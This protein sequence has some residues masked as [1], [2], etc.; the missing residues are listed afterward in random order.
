MNDSNEN[1]LNPE[2]ALSRFAEPQPGANSSELSSTGTTNQ[3]SFTVGHIGFLIALGTFSEIVKDMIIYPIP[4]TKDWMKG[5]VN[6]RGNLVPVYNLALLLGNSPQQSDNIHLLVLGKDSMAVGILID[7]MPEPR[8]TG[9]WN[10]ISEIPGHL[11]SL[12][13]YASKIYS[14]DKKIWLEFN[15]NDYFKSIKEQIVL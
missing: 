13:N 1:W 4:N 5:L 6:L 14:V 2:E 7:S 10:T 12:K 3:Y 11:T 15:H 9:S 8:D